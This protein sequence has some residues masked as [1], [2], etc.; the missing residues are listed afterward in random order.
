MTR[1]TSQAHVRA[2]RRCARPLSTTCIVGTRM[3][4]ESAH[5][6]MRPLA[7][8]L[9]RPVSRVS[10]GRAQLRHSHAETGYTDEQFQW[11]WN[12]LPGMDPNR[13]RVYCGDG[14]FAFALAAR[15]VS[16]MLHCGRAK[17]PPRP[18]APATSVINIHYFDT[19]GD[20]SMSEHSTALPACPKRQH[21][22][23]ASVTAVIALL[24]PHERSCLP[25]VRSHHDAYEPHS[26]ARRGNTPTLGLHAESTSR[27]CCR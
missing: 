5:T 23:H 3:Y 4:K 2:P 25:F 10:H 6:D 16:I 15:A 27:P 21:P 13:L 8:W 12:K 11:A 26:S 17:N 22:T 14:R 19:R 7:L 20:T 24:P 9:P 1:A 18:I